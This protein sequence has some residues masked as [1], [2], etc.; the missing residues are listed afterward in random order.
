MKQKLAVA[1]ALLHRPRSGLPRRAH[2]RARPGRRRRAA[3]RPR[4]PGRRARASTVFLT[5]HNLA[6]AER[7]CARVGVIRDGQAARR[8]HPD[9]LRVQDRRTPRRGRSA[10]ASASAP[11]RR[12]A[13]AAGG[14]LGRAARTA[15]SSIDAARRRETAPLVALLV[16]T[17]CEVEEVRQGPG[18]PG[19]GVPERLVEE[20]RVMR[21][22][23]DLIVW[24]EWQEM[25]AAARQPAR[26]PARHARHRSASSASSC[27][28]RRARL[29][30]VR[31]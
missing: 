1:R 4:R 10:A 15:G 2:R 3:R 27:R 14:G 22:H 8:G 11:A 24:K 13:G 30:G 23:L 6:E 7:L 18:Q 17:A 26:R 31:R 21:R 12:A 9:E 28:S 20:E 25:L 5:T 29:G 16:A 19:G